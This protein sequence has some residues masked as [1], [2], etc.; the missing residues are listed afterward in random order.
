MEF[1][2]KCIRSECEATHFK[3]S[4]NNISSGISLIFSFIF[5]FIIKY[6][7]LTYFK[8]WPASKGR[9]FTSSMKF[10]LGPWISMDNRMGPSKIKD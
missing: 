10:T 6:L 9:V 1:R 4:E 8:G 3:S 7:L 2:Q 5:L